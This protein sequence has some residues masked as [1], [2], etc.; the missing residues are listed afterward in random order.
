ML[1]HLELHLCNIQQKV[2]YFMQN[3]CRFKCFPGYDLVYFKAVPRTISW[4][5]SQLKV[6]VMDTIFEPL[7]IICPSGLKLGTS[8]V[9]VH[10]TLWLSDKRSTLSC[11]KLRV[12][13]SHSLWRQDFSSG[14]WLLIPTGPTGEWETSEYFMIDQM[15]CFTYEA[16]NKCR[17]QFIFIML[18]NIFYVFCVLQHGHGSS[19]RDIS[20]TDITSH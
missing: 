15:E 14:D 16:K 17:P 5:S 20:L 1:Q 9:E 18:L 13:C 10:R 19:R 4:P 8:S 6:E 12:R 7:P 2:L 11:C 3:V